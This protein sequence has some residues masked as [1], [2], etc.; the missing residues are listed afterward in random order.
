MTSRK[1]FG[2]IRKAAGI[3]LAV[4]LALPVLGLLLLLTRP[5]REQ[6]LDIVLSRLRDDLPGRL[7]IAHA[8][9]PSPGVLRLDDVTWTVGRDTL[10][11]IEAAR[12][13]VELAALLR[14]DLHVRELTI[15]C[16]L[17][18]LPAMRRARGYVPPE[19]GSEPRGVPYLRAGALPPL[20]S[21]AVDACQLSCA[22]LVTSEANAVSGIAI[23]GGL[24]LRHEREPR[25][26]L[27]CSGRDAVGAWELVS[28]DVTWAP[29]EGTYVGNGFFRLA[30]APSINMDLQGQ[31]H[32][33]FRLEL[34]VGDGAAPDADSRLVADGRLDGG[35]DSPRTLD[36]N[37]TFVAPDLGALTA[38]PHLTA[39]DGSFDLVSVWD[40]DGPRAELELALAANTWLDGAQV[41]ASYGAGRVRIDTL[42][43]S[44]SGLR[45]SGAADMAEGD[46]DARAQFDATGPE[47][48][49]ILRPDLQAP[50]SLMATAELRCTGPLDA[51]SLT[52]RMLAGARFGDTR[53]ERLA[54]DLD[55]DTGWR[56]GRLDWSLA[57]LGLQVANAVQ[58]TRDDRGITL[59]MTPVDVSRGEVPTLG[60]P[61]GRIRVTFADSTVTADGLRI[62][63]ALG[64]IS[65]HGVRNPR[66]ADAKI[67]AAWPEPPAALALILPDATLDVLRAGWAE[68]A[69]WSIDLDARLGGP[70]R[71][72][73]ELVAGARFR[74]PGPR[75][76]RGLPDAPLSIDDLGP[77]EGK[78]HLEGVAPSLHAE[79][80]LSETDWIETG[81]A[82][83]RFA[84]DTIEVD[85]LHLAAIGIEAAGRGRMRDKR[86]DGE[87][88][89]SMPDAS[90][91]ARLPVPAQVAEAEARA[92]LTARIS[93]TLDRPE[94]EAWIEGAYNDTALSLRHFL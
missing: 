68:G 83:V 78:L 31:G 74:L 45:L 60:E 32:R 14:R 69:P 27:A 28:F 53:L 65:L 80:D 58:M 43:V 48:L 12:L 35:G 76:L 44:A 56:A 61:D 38:L 2:R 21:L 59:R 92:H 16:G 4:L 6:A 15:D 34:A 20:P 87:A 77:L 91:L 33:S 46:V 36:L 39:V 71:N 24:E 88:T 79:L 86:L 66:G 23:G 54:A 42:T 57:T 19:E 63:G 9:W 30:D 72:P 5:V 55:V 29:A 51:P 25:L 8:D 1:R 49:R 93:G 85:T 10:L 11:A 82:A 75:H 62:T 50:D 40:R 81:L 26:H 89:L 22:R 70:G 18:D 67:A 84:G 73:G 64:E 52:A 90:A 94:L 3:S 13:D 7:S 47:W 17:I 41:S 37:G